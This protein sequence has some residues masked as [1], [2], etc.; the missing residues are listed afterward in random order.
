MCGER[1]NNS[2]VYD[3]KLIKT[4]LNCL[5]ERLIVSWAW[6]NAF[7]FYLQ[8]LLRSCDQKQQIDEELEASVLLNGL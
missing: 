2:Q 7:R 3:V 6:L 4:I 8:K 1:D 5:V